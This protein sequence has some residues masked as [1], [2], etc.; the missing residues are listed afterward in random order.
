[1]SLRGVL[2]DNLGL[3]LVALL[4]AVVIYLNAYTDRPAT[5]IVS[6]PVQFQDLA[7]SLTLTGN[8]P[9]TVQAE[10]RGTGKQ[11]IQL[12]VTEP[13]VKLSLA[14]VGLGRY[15]RTLTP[16]DLPLPDG[17]DVS[18]ER[19]VSPRTVD[20]QVDLKGVRE[21]PVAV[22]LEGDP[23]GGAIQTGPVRAVPRALAVTGPVSVLATLDS[24]RLAGIR[25]AGRRDTVT[26]R[27]TPVL[28]QW[29]S[30]SP[31][32]VEVE[33]PIGAA[34]ARRIPLALSAPAGVTGYAVTP[35]RVTAV[36]IAPRA[37]EPELEQLRPQARWSA[38]GPLGE[39]VGTRVGVR[40]VVPL[41]EGMHV[42]FE[43]DSVVLG[44]A[45]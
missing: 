41:P 8:A 3:K 42:R 24:V 34:V 25:V 4:I 35:A 17:V 7:D 45:D 39:R 29:C 10:L 32:V 20:L 11:L 28:P 16:D 43:P 36:I 38:P 21:L 13:A 2:F 1:M 19:M 37:L 30:S 14:G 22:R 31:A 12:R 44:R 40:M 6:F 5:L 27:A 18:V 9:S 26:L 15:E 23:A 33:V